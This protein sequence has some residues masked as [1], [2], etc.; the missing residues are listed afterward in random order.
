MLNGIAIDAQGYF[1]VTDGLDS[2]LL[3]LDLAGETILERYGPE[4]GIDGPDDL[5]LDDNYVYYTS[6][7]TLAGAVG[8]LDRRT[9]EAGVLAATGLGT[10]PIV[11]S[12]AGKLLAGIALGGSGPIGSA[13]RLTG[14]F[15]VDPMGQRPAKRV[16]ADSNG[17]NA[18][19]FAPDGF[20]Y[21]PALSRLVRVHLES[22][23]IETLRDGFGFLG[24]VRYNPR[25][26]ALSCSAYRGL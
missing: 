21:G 9:G 3:R 19:C 26:Q 14:L 8:R 11:W 5:V 20:I 23:A 13:L 22:G 18:F 2:E 17:I 1:W 16:L 10:N 15:E 6:N 24:A 25:D 7:W 12:P 4:R